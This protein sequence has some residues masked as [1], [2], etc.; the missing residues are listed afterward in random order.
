MNEGISY[1]YQFISTLPNRLFVLLMIHSRSSFSLSLRWCLI[2]K[3][4]LTCL[5]F[6][7]FYDD[8]PINS[9]MLFSFLSACVLAHQLSILP[10]G[11]DF[12][13]VSRFNW[14]ISSSILLTHVLMI[15]LFLFLWRENDA[16]SFHLSDLIEEEERRASFSSTT[17]ISSLL[18]DRTLERNKI[19]NFVCIYNDC[20]VSWFSWSIWN[21]E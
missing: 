11:I 5:S 8:D 6:F 19:T 9:E 15:N 13:S 16:F 17:I 14:T 7:F 10:D 18:T 21:M 4:K 3:C 12:C 20:I 1:Q 2:E